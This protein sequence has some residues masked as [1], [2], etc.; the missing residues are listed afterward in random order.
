MKR[1]LLAGA[2][3]AVLCVGLVASVASAA[4]PPGNAACLQCHSVTAG[5]PVRPVD[6]R[7]PVSLAKC[8]ACH[9]MSPDQG[10]HEKVVDSPK[11]SDCHGRDNANVAWAG[12]YYDPVAGRF[13]SSASL[14][15]S[16]EE[17]HRIHGDADWVTNGVFVTQW[18]KNCH[19]AASCDAC[20][21][22][23]ATHGNHVASQ[24][25]VASYAPV[26]TMVCTGAAGAVYIESTYNYR[27]LPVTCYASA[28]HPKTKLAVGA[29]LPACTD[30]HKPLDQHYAPDTHVSSWSM[31]GCLESGCHDSRDLVAEHEA[32]RPGEGCTLCHGNTSDPRY[33]A[34]IAAGD[35]A[36]GACHD[37]TS[38][39]PHR[40][41]HWAVPPLVDSSGPHYGYYTGSASTAPTSDCIMCHTSNLVDE[42]M[43]TSNGVVTRLPRYASDGTPLSCDSCHKSTKLEVIGAIAAGKT[44]CEACHPVHG[45]IYGATHRSTFTPAGDDGCS[46]CHSSSLVDAHEGVSATT[47]SGRQLNGCDVCHGY[48]EGERGQQVQFA[49]EVA[50][51]TRCTACHAEYHTGATAKHTA[52]DA[53]SIDACA[54]CHGTAGQ[55]MDVTQV[56]A[57]A[58]LGGCKVCHA[59]PSRVPDIT[60]K[61][62]ACAS[63]HATEGTDYHRNLPAAHTFGAMPSTCVG[64]RCHA[65]NTLPEAHAPYL[66]RYPQYPTT[67]ALC[68]SNEDP[69]RIDWSAASADCSSCHTVHGDIAAIHAAP[70]SQECVDCHETADVRDLHGASQDESC[71]YC[72]NASLELPAT[73]KCVNCHGVLSPVDPNHYPPAAHDASAESGCGQC[74][75]KDMKAEHFKPTVGVS[76]VQCHEVKVD[77]F[78]APWDKTCA[79]CHPTKHSERQVKHQSTNTA[80]AGT[81]CHDITNVESVHASLAGGGCP[82]CHRAPDKPATTT[83][84][85]VCHTGVGPNHHEQHDASSANPSGCKGCHY[86]YLDDE[87]AAL[88]Y[89]CG[90]CH[91]STN[92][93]VRATI[94]AGDRRCLS[95]HPDSPHNKRQAWEFTPNMSSGHRVS[96][97]LPGMKSSFTVNGQAYTWTLPA[98][99]SFLKTGWATDSVMSCD[100]C[101]TYSGASGPHGAA[102]KVNIDPAYPTSWKSAYLQNTANGMSSTT[103]ICAKCHDLNGPSGSWSNK[104]HGTGDHQG[105]TKGKCILCHAQVPHGWK[106][107][108]LL[109]YTSDGA[110]YASTGLTGLK[111]K[112]Y[113]P[114]QWSEGDC[115][116]SCGEHGSTVTPLWP[117][118]LDP[119]APTTGDLAGT[120]TNASTGAAVSG[121]TVSVAGKTATTGADGKYSITGIAGGSY[122]MTV[123]ATGYQSWSGTVTVANGV[124]T[125]VNVQLTPQPAGGDNLALGKTFT[126]SRYESADY[127]PGKAGDGSTS[128]F[129]WSKRDGGAS[130][131]EWLKVDL[132]SRTSV[133]KVEVAWYGDYWAKEFR[134]YVSTDD[135]NWTEVYSTTSAPKGTTTITFSA[136]D[137]RYVRVECRKTGTGRNNGYGIAELRVFK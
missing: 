89:S 25:S 27:T 2:V 19:L 88:G 62:A 107:P 54:S 112:S 120:V 43:G 34:A 9:S 69:G 123:S 119:N 68:H 32:R 49:I 76:C 44:N 23:P 106:R 37:A 58:A 100:A 115:S 18:C 16:P 57:D 21:D 105:S 104:V 95:C 17:L 50:N 98:A 82:A 108:R 87:H 128:T 60:Q 94:E 80:C 53:A 20:H 10:I 46:G 137:A 118:V 85:T 134:V 129:W 3:V 55:P 45:P 101:H 29:E 31:D 122:T 130:D 75:Y 135:R 26:P 65:A 79:A 121:A 132:G 11:C 126:A 59:N 13:A 77:A 33:A 111:L 96:S 136:R 22:A 48:Y 66:S 39:D 93:T 36:C 99:S 8:A 81:G 64:S 102:M 113:T 103:V 131:T 7:A 52:D 90:T 28:C 5:A 92:A 109:A 124:T 63:C 73:T 15:T 14:M 74:H 116:T 61:T 42:H 91:A 4:A 133:S 56:H 24:S 30:C 97:D 70:D 71:D 84:C 67:C 1:L 127:A 78:T 35:T 41:I 114:T 38:A 110:P 12:Q 6:F 72:H 83:D 51:D 117:L 47:P 86:M 125:T 40:S